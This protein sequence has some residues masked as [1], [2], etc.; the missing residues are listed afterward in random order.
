MLFPPKGFCTIS[1]PFQVLKRVFLARDEPILGRVGHNIQSR[2][3]S[4]RKY[5]KYRKYLPLWFCKLANSSE[6][7]RYFFLIES[8]CPLWALGGLGSH[9]IC[10]FTGVGNYFATE[11]G[12]LLAYNL[13]FFIGDS[14]WAE[15]HPFTGTTAACIQCLHPMVWHSGN[16]TRKSDPVPCFIFT[17]KLFASAFSTNSIIQLRIVTVYSY[18]A[19]G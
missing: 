3:K 18:L 7:E 5:R 15:F 2:R 13:R 12:F 17:M 16:C 8:G 11:K 14:T 19:E 9:R 6:T 10:A 1:G 4:G